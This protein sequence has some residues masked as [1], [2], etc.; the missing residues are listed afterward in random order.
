[1]IIEKGSDLILKINDERGN[2]IRVSNKSSFFIRVF[3]TDKSNYLEYGKDDVIERNDYDTIHISANKLQQ[4]E[5]GV[6]AYT[7]GWG[8]S[9][10]NFDDGEFNCLKT[11]YTNFYYNNKENS[12]SGGNIENKELEDIKESIANLSKQVNA[13]TVTVQDSTLIITT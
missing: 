4:L 7:Y 11:I 3:T 10:D 6:I 8:I 2:G 5:S 13:H 12:S 9:D 1:M